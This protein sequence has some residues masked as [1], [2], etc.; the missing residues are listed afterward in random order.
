[1]N[2]LVPGEDRDTAGQDEGG[3]LL[4]DDALD[5]NGRTNVE[6]RNRSKLGGSTSTGGDNGNGMSAGTA[7]DNELGLGGGGGG[8]GGNGDGDGDGGRAARCRAISL[9]G[10]GARI[11]HF[12]RSEPLL[13]FTLIGVILGLCLGT[14][15]SS[16]PSWLL[17]ILG[18]PGMVFLRLLKM[19][20]LPLIAGSIIAGVCS[21]AK[22]GSGGS[23]AGKLAATALGLYALTMVI[24]V[25]T[26]IVYVSILRP[27]R[28]VDSG[29]GGCGGD[30]DDD[31]NGATDVTV[32]VKKVSPGEA[33]KNVLL[34]M[35]PTNIVQAAAN[36]NVLGVISFSVLF[37][38]A[39]AATIAST[40]KSNEKDERDGARSL[41][42]GIESFNAAVTKMVS[43]V[44]VTSPVGI[45]SLILYTV[46]TS[47]G[48][49]KVFRALGAY[50]LC[51]T[52]ALGT[53]ALLTLPLVLYGIGRISPLRVV[54]AFA[55]AFVTAFGTDSSSATLPVTMRCASEYGCDS[56]LTSFVLPLGATINMDGTALYE[57]MTVIFI[58]QMHGEVLS[59][60]QTLVVAFTATLAAVGAASIPSA[61]LVTMVM[62]LEAVNRGVYAADIGL[63]FTLDWL[64][65]RMRTTVNV[66]G[67]VFA[68]VILDKLFKRGSR[69]GS[70][71]SGTGL[72]M[73]PQEL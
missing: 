35:A 20:V 72:M 26:G 59:F 55:P 17:E 25:V 65:D 63:V 29:A 16:A 53:H 48:I 3:L 70:R 11:R 57:A 44:L 34:D 43:W 14:A 37:G 13:F 24:A 49:G 36:F 28:G 5:V 50:L 42:S 27:G 12:V 7:G 47:C 40:P 31:E 2:G 69:A 9:R 56:G 46:A 39:I 10:I 15:L 67:D 64:L 38:A 54:R 1:M 68:L 6:E 23:R 62:V 73:T 30:D 41:L 45:F 58:L 61:G 4:S 21:I 18:F 32:N 51:Y 22:D 60:A 66:Q 8:G 33:I 19:L 52:L 71:G